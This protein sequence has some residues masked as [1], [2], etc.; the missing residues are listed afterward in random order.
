MASADALRAGRVAGEIPDPGEDVYRVEGQRGPLGELRHRTRTSSVVSPFARLSDHHHE[1]AQVEEPVSIE[2]M[3]YMGGFTFCDAPAPATGDL[4]FLEEWVALKVE[5]KGWTIKSWVSPEIPV[6][7]IA[8][9]DV[10][11]EQVAKS[12]VGAAVLFGVIGAAGAKA[13]HDR[14]T[15]TIYL[16]SGEAGF[17]TT[18]GLPPARVQ[19]IIRPWMRAKDIPFGEPG[20]PPGAAQPAAAIGVAD[21]LAKLA[22]LKAS[23]VLTEEEFEQQKA[24]LLGLS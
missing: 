24:R 17:F 12:K 7:A 6:G 13:T 18:E 11:S 20:G 4:M 19:A 10:T 16:N 22:Q 3:T 8:S 1:G 23:G 21:E 2:R 9:I 14:A 15:I 5:V